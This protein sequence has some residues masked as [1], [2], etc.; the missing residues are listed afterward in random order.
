MLYWC[1]CEGAAYAELRSQL[2]S[3]PV[4][5]SPTIVVSLFVLEDHGIVT[6]VAIL[7]YRRCLLKTY[8]KSETPRNDMKTLTNIFKA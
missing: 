3:N 7:Q 6:Q 4:L 5:E 1:I 2:F 8:Q